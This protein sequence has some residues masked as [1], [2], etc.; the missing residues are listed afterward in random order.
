MNVII[1]IY[2]AVDKNCD[3]KDDLKLFKYDDSEVFC[4]E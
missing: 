2:S 4:L 3:C 1:N